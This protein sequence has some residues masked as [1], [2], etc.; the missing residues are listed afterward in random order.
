MFISEDATKYFIA[1]DKQFQIEIEKQSPL[2]EVGGVWKRE[3]V[4]QC[5]YWGGL[6]F[7][8]QLFLLSLVRDYYIKWN[9]LI[10]EFT[11]WDST[12]GCSVPLYVTLVFINYHIKQKINKKGVFGIYS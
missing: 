2:N 7:Y 8:Y 6:S 9:L 11:I 3:R 10:M 12:L 1:N 5:K 4:L